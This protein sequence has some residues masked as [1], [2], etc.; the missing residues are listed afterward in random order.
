VVAGQAIKNLCQ[1]LAKTILLKVTDAIAN[2]GPPRVWDA[3]WPA[4]SSPVAQVALQ[5]ALANIGAQCEYE[6]VIVQPHVRST[7]YNA[8]INSEPAKKLRTLLFGALAMAKASGA[9]LR[10]VIDDQ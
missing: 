4:P 5:V 9:T 1:I 10:V 2:A 7:F 3:P 8:K 6:V